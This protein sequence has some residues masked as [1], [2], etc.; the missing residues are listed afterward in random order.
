VRRSIEDPYRRGRIGGVLAIVGVSDVPLVIMA[1][2]WFRGVHPVTPEMDLTMRCVLLACVCS[3][4]AMFTFLIIQRR[5]QLGASERLAQREAEIW[6][7]RT[8]PSC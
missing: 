3:F 7:A 5:Q 4:T 8:K 6:W 1:T 2:R